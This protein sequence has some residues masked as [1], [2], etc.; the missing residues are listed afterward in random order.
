[1]QFLRARRT[2]STDSSKTKKAIRRASATAI[3][4]METRQMMA[5]S[6]DASGWTKIT[7]SSDTRQVFV[8]SSTGSDSNDGL[9]ASS[10]VKTIGKG[11]SLLRSGSPDWLELKRGD[12]F[13][14][15]FPTWGKSG[16]NAQEPM[17]ITSYGDPNAPRP[18]IK[19]GNARGFYSYMTLHDLAMVG[20][21]FS[22]N[23]RDPSSPDFK[24]TDGAYGFQLVGPSSNILV[25]DTSFDHYLNAATVQGFNGYMTNIKFRRDQFLDSYD[26][27]GYKAIGLYASQ[28]DGLVIEESVFDHNGWNEEISTATASIYSH[29][30]YLWQTTKNSVVRNNI[31][32]EAGSHGLQA[33]GGGIIEGNLFLKNPIGA[34]LGNGSEVTA[35]GV[36]GKIVGNV[37]TEDRDTNGATRGW[38]IEVGN[39]K[40]GGGTVISDNI[41]TDD[42]QNKYAAIQLQVDTTASNSST[43]VG[44]ND[45]TIERNI[46]YQWYQALSIASGFKIGGTGATGL[47]DLTVTDNDFQSTSSQKI[48]HQAQAY[49]SAEEDFSGNRYYNAQSSTGWF[50]LNNAKTSLATWQSK[51]EPDAVSQKMDYAD[52]DR[53][54]ATYN[55]SIG[56]SKSEA[57][58][59]SAIRNNDKSGYDADLT[60]AAVVSYIR[61]G[62]T[63]AAPSSNGGSSGGSTGGSTGGGTTTP[64]AAPTAD[65]TSAANVTTAGG[66]TQT[67][68]VTYTDDTAISAASLGNYDIKV[69]G[70]NGYSQIGTLVGVDK[71]GDGTP[72]TA[73]YSITAPGGTWDSVDNGTYSVSV[74]SNGIKDIVGVFAPSQSLGSFTASVPAA[75]TG[76]SGNSNGGASAD[77]E[78]PPSVLWSNFDPTTQTATVKFSE[79]VSKSMNLSDMRMKNVKTFE[80]IAYDQM[81]FSYDKSTNI[82]TWTFN[83]PL[84]IADYK[85]IVSA[86]GVTD[87]AGNHLDGNN[88]GRGGDDHMFY[89][90]SA[91]LAAAAALN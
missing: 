84:P 76:G 71:T 85:V 59:L 1:M 30:I 86:A 35:G 81:S 60:A 10:P 19:T 65:L 7:P 38:A 36:S 78:T 17:V 56:G 18:W 54:V 49:N 91:E 5:V 12:V 33:R 62:F 63:G 51:V 73:T 28:T 50:Y 26:G 31:I 34:L 82:G 40:A 61:A 29:N 74:L 87:A 48:I 83:K 66:T 27:T 80:L 22:A 21:K 89:V 11:A 55:A 52:P 90:T 41:M 70:P 24:S 2:R 13:T 72:R 25:E 88:T 69:V 8:S 68:K 42:S 14:D 79:D 64:N 47:N 77:D 20:L 37:F 39:T 16:R 4:A 53:T 45:L 43:G 23:G 75:S 32:A 9:S 58:F 57:A 6:L 3:E 44:I 67:I 15:A 46:V